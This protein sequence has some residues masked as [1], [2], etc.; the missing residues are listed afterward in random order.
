MLICPPHAHIN[1]LCDVSAGFPPIK[2]VGDGFS[3]LPA[4]TGTQGIGVS[5]PS[6]AA[7]AAATV[8]FNML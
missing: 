2:T 3:Q 5:T 7:V 4:G 1:V 8:G 6:A